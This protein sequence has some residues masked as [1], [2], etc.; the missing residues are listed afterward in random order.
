M[1]PKALAVTGTATFYYLLSTLNFRFP[2]PSTPTTT[3]PPPILRSIKSRVQRFIA[4]VSMI[5]TGIT[6]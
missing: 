4:E 6:V 5:S 2:D 3:T 1:F